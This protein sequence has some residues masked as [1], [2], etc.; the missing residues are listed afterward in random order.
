MPNAGAAS[1]GTGGEDPPARLAAGANAGEV[2]VLGAGPA[3]GI[4]FAVAAEGAVASGE[5][6]LRGAPLGGSMTAGD[7]FVEAGL[8]AALTPGDR[9]PGP[10]A[11]PYMGVAFA[12]EKG[13]S[14]RA[15]GA[16][17]EAV[18]TA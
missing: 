8:G 7:C 5:A 16:G 12:L 18:G 3:S 6:A 15:P 13:G 2:M 14:F 17:G 10:G 4:W 11:G 9:E 1:G